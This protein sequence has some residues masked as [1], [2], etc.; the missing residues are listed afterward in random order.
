MTSKAPRKFARDTRKVQ[1]LIHG[2]F[3]PQN[4]PQLTFLLSFKY[5]DGKSTQEE[6]S[7]RIE[8][9]SSPVPQKGKKSLPSEISNPESSPFHVSDQSTTSNESAAAIKS[10]EG[11]QLS[12][13]QPSSDQHHFCFEV[14]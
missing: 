13:Y 1:K 5:K 3:M 8:H 14:G 4:S 9:D 2:L 10:L 7:D 6:Q 11:L 12:L